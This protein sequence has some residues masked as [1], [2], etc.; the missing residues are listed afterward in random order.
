VEAGTPWRERDNLDVI[1]VLDQPS[2][3]ILLGLVDECPVVPKQAQTPPHK[4]PLR[5]AADFEFISE[6]RQIT[7]VREFVESLP[8]KLA[9]P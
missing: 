5:V 6:N 3:A 1:A 9:E 7:W 8:A 2:W 4:R